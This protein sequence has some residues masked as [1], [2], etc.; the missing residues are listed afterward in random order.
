[1]FLEQERTGSM[2][3][4]PHG[5]R[6]PVA[7]RQRRLPH[8]QSQDDLPGLPG[9]VDLLTEKLDGEMNTAG[10]ELSCRAQVGV[11]YAYQLHK[12]HSICCV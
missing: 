5:C 6:P 4:M 10:A 9:H 2:D 11:W 8:Q 12:K 3:A 7:K 1:M